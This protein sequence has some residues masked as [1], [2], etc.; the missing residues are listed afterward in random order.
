MTFGTWI[1]G[2]RD[3]NPNVTAE[4]TREI[5]RLQHHAAARAITDAIETLIAELSSSTTVV[6]ASPQLL[7][8]IDADIT[9]L[10]GLDPRL[11]VVN[12]TEPYRL[13]LTCMTAKIA[14][15]RRRVDA[16]TPHTPGRDYLGKT[17][18]IAE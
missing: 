7:A 13:K 8:S 3:G 9:A 1:G 12:A 18:L 11:L 17:E 2:D 6:D 5:L 4:V 16:G 10:P 15:T 14:N